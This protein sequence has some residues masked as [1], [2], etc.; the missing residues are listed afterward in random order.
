VRVGLHYRK[1]AI[2][3]WAIVPIVFFSLAKTKMQGYIVFA[4]PALLVMTAEFFEMLTRHVH[5]GKYKRALQIILVLLIALPLRYTMER[6][7]PF[8][9]KAR[10]P[11]WMKQLHAF[12][13]TTTPN[14]VL[15]NYA[16]PIEAMFYTN[17]AA[18]YEQLPPRAILD[19]LQ[20]AGY[21]IVINR[22]NLSDTT[23]YGMPGVRY[24]NRE[25]VIIVRDCK[26]V[27]TA[28]LEYQ[29]PRKMKS[30]SEFVVA[31]HV[32]IFYGS[33]TN[34]QVAA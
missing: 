21:S 28:Y 13:R 10:K 33:T 3:I 22:T 20:D 19:S 26:I 23:Y 31:L 16:K 9:A 6:V 8:A 29:L 24:A 18:A 4:A 1:L 27:R 5:S 34:F 12:A 14:T 32:S 17:V 7:K 15:F 2:V 25:R 30:I 11:D